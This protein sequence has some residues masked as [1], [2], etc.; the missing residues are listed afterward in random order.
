M[1]WVLVIT[2]V[3]G[4]T[5]TREI[6]ATFSAPERCLESALIFNAISTENSSQEFIKAECVGVEY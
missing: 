6:R 5:T 1:F 2:T 3:V 4:I